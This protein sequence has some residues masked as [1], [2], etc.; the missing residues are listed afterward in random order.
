MIT[1]P[2]STG[3]VIEPATG[4][5]VERMQ[6][7]SRP[8]SVVGCWRHELLQYQLAS[9]SF[10]KADLPVSQPDCSA[11]WSEPGRTTAYRD[12]STQTIPGRAIAFSQRPVI[13]PDDDWKNI[14]QRQPATDT[15][16]AFAVTTL[17]DHTGRSQRQFFFSSKLY[18]EITEV[19]AQLF[20]K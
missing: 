11:S 15:T 20:S 7:L 16:F 5:L 18:W 8:R 4:P 13:G 2:L 3:T 12:L 14:G 10:A 19:K 17:S 1:L 6:P 9:K